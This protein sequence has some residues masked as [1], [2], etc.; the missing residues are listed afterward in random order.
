VCFPIPLALAGIAVHW[1]LYAKR[2]ESI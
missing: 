2:E 1:F